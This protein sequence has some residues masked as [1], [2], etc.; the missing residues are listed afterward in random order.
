MVRQNTVNVRRKLAVNID[1]SS[2]PASLIPSNS[3]SDDTKQSTLRP[4]RDDD[5][6][7]TLSDQRLI[8]GHQREK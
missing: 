8:G 7:G 2:K 3:D 4:E 6:A 5:D 1:L